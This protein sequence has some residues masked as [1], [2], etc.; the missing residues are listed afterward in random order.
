MPQVEVALQ[1]CSDAFSET[2]VGFANS[3]RTIDGGT[4]IEGLRSCLTKTLN[5]LAKRL[6]VAKEADGNLPGG[7]WGCWRGCVS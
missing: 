7:G 1:W 3:I 4:H 2:T 5:S 6:K